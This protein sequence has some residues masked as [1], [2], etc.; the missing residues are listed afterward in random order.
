LEIHWRNLSSLDEELRARIEERVR[1]LAGDKRDLIDVHIAAKT[2]RHHVHGG[3]EV[4]VRALARGREIVASRTR[5][6]LELALAE[7]LDA[8]ERELRRFRERNSERRDVRE[9]APPEQGVIDRVELAEGYGFILTDAGERVYFH[10]NAL[11]PELRFEELEEGQR[12]GLNFE[13]GEKGLQ[14][15]VVLRAPA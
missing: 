1:A 7:A 5:P 3:R 12:I 14:A 15:T 2:T 9:P 6:D 4:S 13:A 10:R 11:R 8:F